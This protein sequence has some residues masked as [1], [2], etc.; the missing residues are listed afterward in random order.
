MWEKPLASNSWRM[1]ATRPSIMSEGAT[2]SAPARACESADGA[3]RDPSLGI[4]PGVHFVL[5]FR[6]AEQDHA[7]DSERPHLRALMHDFVHGQLE[8]AGHGPNFAADALT[9]AGEQRQDEF[10]R[11]QAGLPHQA[12]DRL[13][14]T[15]PAHAVYGE[16]HPLNCS[17]GRFESPPDALASVKIRKNNAKPP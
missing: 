10:R 1:A 5:A 14:G 11:I 6:Q 8:I 3:L 13:A 9:G 2:I 7:A 17:S 12:A 16:R 4:S 15:Q